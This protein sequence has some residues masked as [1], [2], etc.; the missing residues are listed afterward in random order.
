MTFFIRLIFLI[1]L[2]TLV[3]AGVFFYGQI[4]P[5][6]KGVIAYSKGEWA[7][8]QKHY[9]DANRE[10][11]VAVLYYPNPAQAWEKL[12]DS[13]RALNHPEEAMADYQKTLR[14]NPGNQMAMVKLA[15]LAQNRPEEALASNPKAEE[16]DILHPKALA[17]SIMDQMGSSKAKNDW[18]QYRQA[19]QLFEH[20]EYGESAGIYCELAA[21]YPESPETLYSSAITL[22]KIG[23]YPLANRVMLQAAELISST[24]PEQSK[25][26]AK[27]AFEYHAVASTSQSPSNADQDDHAA[28]FQKLAALIEPAIP[29]KN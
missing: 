26:W 4:K 7:Y 12:G 19:K 16:V 1:I 6:A 23:Q 5:V 22:A 2:F 25:N 24:Q 29:Q 20:G 21:K 11:H 28:C 13:E 15:S 3:G 27:L 9:E 14:L 17:A 18:S 8:S 10:Y